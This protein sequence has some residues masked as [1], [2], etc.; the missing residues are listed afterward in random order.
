I[1]IAS[2]ITA[3]TIATVAAG[4]QLQAASGNV[5]ITAT[6]ANNA[7]ATS[8]NIGGGGV[9]VQVSNPSANDYSTTKAI[10]LGNLS[11]SGL[12]V[13]AIA[14]DQSVA[15]AGSFGGGVVQVGVAN[16]N[17]TTA[18]TVKAQIG[19]TVQVTNNIG[20]HAIATSEA[21]TTNSSGSGGAV[22]V[23]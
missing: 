6:S 14:D 10:M 20:V 5:A 22:N 19:G 8:E 2:G 18:P 7:S 1:D 9:N 11:A 15:G 16:V 4:A 17:A 23:S 13:Q 21:D 3:A 12:L